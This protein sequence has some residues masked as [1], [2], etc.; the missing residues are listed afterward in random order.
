MIIYSV[1]IT[2]KKVV[3]KEWLK[4][5]KEI[6]IK[7]VMKTGYF[8]S[9][10]I[11]IRKAPGD[12]PGEITYLINYFAESLNKYEKYIKK[13]APRLQREHSERFKKKFRATRNLYTLIK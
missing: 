9:W 13:E 12:S 4:W 11:Y 3:E 1:T 5:M 2:V 8:T 10:Q 7:D 6:H